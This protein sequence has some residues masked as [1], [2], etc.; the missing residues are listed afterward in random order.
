MKSYRCETGIVAPLN[1]PNI[2]TDQIL[3]KQFLKKVERTGFGE[4]L[5][6]DWRFQ[7]NGTADENFVLNQPRFKSASILVAGENF[8]CGSSREH[9]PWGLLDYGFH[10]II[11][12][13]FADIF[14]NN[15]FKN[16]MLPVILPASEVNK[17]LK[18]AAEFEQYELTV[19]LEKQEVFD[20][21]G[22]K[23][24]FQVDE[25]RRYCLL[26]GLDDIGLTLRHE[27]AISAFENSRPN[28][29]NVNG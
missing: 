25:F 19:D 27:S 11:S 21:F 13:S 15:C 29:L 16:G 10:T 5:F 8:G 2:D 24:T 17:L 14:Y 3:P 9:A 18:N 12:T 28:W 20:K 1:R 22:F 6:Y 7:P 26:N 4:F 23:T